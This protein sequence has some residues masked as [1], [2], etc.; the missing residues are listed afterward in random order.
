MASVL[1]NLTYRRLLT[2]QVVALLGTGLLTVGLGLLAYDLEPD[3]AATV[4]ATALTI[5]MVVY[6]VGSPVMAALT[7]R[8]R[9]RLVLVAADL[10]RLAAAA[11]LPLIDATWQ[12]YALMAALHLAS[13]TFTPTFQALIPEILPDED[14]YTQ[15]LSLSR[16]AYDLEALVS[17]AAAGLLLLVV[18]VPLLFVATAVGFAASAVLVVTTLP[19]TRRR[20]VTTDQSF[21]RRTTSGLRLVGRYP[22]LRGLLVVDAAIACSTSFALVASTVVVHEQLGGGSVGLAI[23]LGSF[24]LGS[25][26][27][28]LTSPVIARRLDVRSIVL[29]GATAVPVALGAVA[30]AVTAGTW[31]G[32]LATWVLLGAATSAAITLSG[33]V[34]AAAVE[35]SARSAVFAARFSTSH[36]WFLLGY[37]LTGALLA[38]ADPARTA[39]ALAGLS[40]VAAVA[41]R[42]SWRVA[43]P[44]GA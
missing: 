32:V 17:P 16:L 24:G 33:R 30:L 44:T 7:I 39:L 23:A 8:L 34:V 9:P 41:A 4:V 28:A 27:V 3:S 26:G 35:P 22:A 37:P 15:A 25:M 13:A 42:R 12:A 18:D 6:V 36:A 20:P 31:L 43:V 14:D 1:R 10:V 2:A 5:K 11:T 21:W 40:L 19:R 29:G 38:L